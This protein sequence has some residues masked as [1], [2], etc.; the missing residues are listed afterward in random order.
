MADL[1]DINR[2][3][4]LTDSEECREQGHFLRFLIASKNVEAA[5]SGL[6][7]A[8][9]RLKTARLQ[10]ERVEDA[11]VKYLEGRVRL[12]TIMKRAREEGGSRTPPR[13]SRNGCARLIES[14]RLAPR[15]RTCPPH[16]V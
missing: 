13:P 15:P 7:A 14:T 5:E 12:P 3:E 6:A 9:A 4:V 10:K 8:R 16:E 1:G 11:F 2:S